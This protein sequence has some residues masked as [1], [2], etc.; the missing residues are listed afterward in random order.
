MRPHSRLSPTCA[1]LKKKKLIGSSRALLDTPYGESLSHSYRLPPSGVIRQAVAHHGR[2]GELN[3]GEKAAVRTARRPR[4]GRRRQG[5]AR[6][7]PAF[8]VEKTGLVR[9]EVFRIPVFPPY[10]K[11]NHA[12]RS[13]PVEGDVT[14]LPKDGAEA[15]SDYASSPGGPMRRHFWT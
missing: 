10:E 2:L 13:E 8:C 3:D 11:A 4:I 5:E 1:L 6:R 12:V 7:H 15:L 9:K 14:D